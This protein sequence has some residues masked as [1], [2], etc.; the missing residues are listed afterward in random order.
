MTVAADI[1][2]R[3]VVDPKTYSDEIAYHDLFAQLRAHDPV[4]WVEPDGFR[5]FWLISKHADILEIERQPKIFLNAPRAVLRTIAD[6]ERIS[7]LNGGEHLIRSMNN[8]DGADHRA[9]RNITQEDFQKIPIAKLTADVDE[10]AAEFVERVVA[11]TPECDFVATAAAWY[12][13]RVIMTLFG[14]PPQQEGEMLDLT[15]RL[16]GAADDDVRKSA[17]GP[18]NPIE[19]IQA[20]FERFRPVIQE[21]RLCPR[22]DIAGKIA[23]APIPDFEALSYCVTIA[24]AGHDTTSAAIS[25]GLL[26]LIRNPGEMAKLRAN[27]ELLDTAVDEMIRWT[28]PVK[29]FFRTATQEYVLRG[30]TIRQGDSLMLAFPSGSRDEDVFPEAGMFRVDREPN[31]HL[32]LGSGPHVCLGQHLARLEMKRF[33]SHLLDRLDDIELAGEPA[34]VDGWFISGVKRLPIRYRAKG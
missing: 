2:N 4:S 20:F 8:M 3:A 18:K 26:A 5:P 32:A 34:Y 27:S 24:T 9:N 28:A 23:A 16:F 6:E 22:D 29:H 14:I 17:G 31:R 19:T 7:K 33:F 30:R 25:G 15:R 1:I 12:P 21:R 13:L 11:R 10:I